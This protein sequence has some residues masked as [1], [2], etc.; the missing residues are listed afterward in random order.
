MKKIRLLAILLAILMIPFSAFFACND[1]EEPSDDPGQNEDPDEN[2]G[3]TKP[4]KPT[5]VGDKTVDD[6]TRTGYLAFFSFDNAD[7]GNLGV[8]QA[9][10]DYNDPN[11]SEYAGAKPIKPY[12]TYL[13]GSLVAGAAYTVKEKNEGKYLSIQR[14]NAVTTPALDFYMGYSYIGDISSS[15]IIEFQLEFTKGLFGAETSFGGVKGSVTQPLI[16]IDNDS[17]KDCYGNVIYGDKETDKQGWIKITVAIDDAAETYTV[18]ID[19]VKQAS[20]LDYSN[21]NYKS[22]NEM[23]P[24]R[25]RFMISN[26][27]RLDTYLRID[28]LSI[29][30]GTVDDLDFEE[31]DVENKIFGTVSS[32]NSIISASE[33]TI[34][35]FYESRSALAESLK[36]NLF[37]NGAL[38]SDR[39][40][41]SKI[42]TETGDIADIY[43]DYGVFLGKYGEKAVF[44][45]EN[46]EFTFGT[47]DGSVVYDADKTDADNAVV[48]GAYTVAEGVITF[49][50]AEG[51]TDMPVAAKF[52]DGV[53]TTYSDAECTAEL[54]AYAYEAVVEAGDNGDLA[55]DEILGIKFSNIT[56]ITSDGEISFP[57]DAAWYRSHKNNITSLKLGMYISEEMYDA[58]YVFLIRFNQNG[59][60]YGYY[61]VKPG[62]SSGF[63]NGTITYTVGLNEWTIE[64]S[65][66]ING[67]ANPY[68]LES[69]DIDIRFTFTGWTNQ[70]VN[71]HHDDYTFYLTEFALVCE[72]LRVE[73]TPPADGM[74]DCEHEDDIGDSTLIKVDTPI[75]GNCA[76]GSYYVLKCT[77]CG[78]TEVDESRPFGELANHV[79]DDEIHE[80]LA[81]CLEDGYTYKECTLC[82]TREI[83]STVESDGH[84][85]ITSG[86]N[87][88]QVTQ[89]CKDCGDENTVIVRTE[90]IS[91]EQKIAELGLLEG[92]RAYWDAEG[93]SVNI[94]A[95]GTISSPLM[96]SVI[97][98]AGGFEMK[99]EKTKYGDMLV[100]RHP[101]KDTKSN[102][103]YIDIAPY[104][105]G[106][107]TTYFKAQSFAYEFDF[108]LGESETG[109]YWDVRFGLGWRN[110]SIP[111]ATWGMPVFRADGTMQLCDY[112]ATANVI[113]F[114]S[115]EKFK[116]EVGQLYNIAV[117]MDLDNNL[118]KL[119]IDG[120]FFD[121]TQFVAS[122]EEAAIFSPTHL[123]LWCGGANASG[124]SFYIDNYMHYPVFNAEPVCVLTSGIS[125]G[126]GYEGDIELQ[127]ELFDAIRPDFKVMADGYNAKLN[128]PVDLYLK[129]YVLELGI[130][131]EALADGTVL[132][133]IKNGLGYDRFLDVIKV[134]DG[135]VY[136]CDVLVA[137]TTKNVKL[138]L[139][140]DDNL[141]TI[142]V[143]VN[144][145]RVAGT[146]SFAGDYADLAASIRSFVLLNECGS[147]DVTGLKM[148]TGTEVK[149]D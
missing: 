13:R 86:V 88:L 58:G 18:F 101:T 28:D 43:S 136:V 50:F 46:A 93:T 59:G 137:K 26:S 75:E 70:G 60:G 30:N 14:V 132:R 27:T 7:V 41:L 48:E 107:S 64:L 44:S 77:I 52:A 121:E 16:T 148:Y 11:Y 131:A 10:T 74:A 138:A 15:H 57:W 104:G 129:E 146:V 49:T 103:S 145:E 69:D 80:V 76:Y 119:Y 79:F 24:D 31:S 110:G 47:F 130:N 71:S 72:G 122:L 95:G 106:T 81:T 55:E 109:A 8:I 82:G 22:W 92:D 125:A 135:R 3:G 128:V 98:E 113:N 112:N 91:F 51:V 62:T 1:P 108:V 54:A 143:F 6:G 84:H 97:K 25:Y 94:T 116:F 142:T 45:S 141:N 61:I 39:V 4:N 87:G 111:N 85:Y 118:V 29:R 126:S 37:E 53:L 5:S 23:D 90:M 123:R 33:D 134:K 34:K 73:L 17:I 139:V 124:G 78:A 149:A 12:Y 9:P 21:P 38:L 100:W 99:T 117:V 19:G 105:S 40:T 32:F 144:G 127:D 114:G 66:L 63:D 68:S 42:N 36:Q 2:E 56:K 115:H 140:F 133:A 102:E 20:E 35:S 120:V 89:I 83:L 147:Y 67:N 96:T 65:K